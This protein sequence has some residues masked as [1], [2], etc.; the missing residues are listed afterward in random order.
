MAAFFKHCDEPS[1]SLKGT[2]F[3]KLRIYGRKIWVKYCYMHWIFT[4]SSSSGTLNFVPQ[5]FRDFMLH[6][7]ASVSNSHT[8]IPNFE[9][10]VIMSWCFYRRELFTLI[11]SVL[12]NLL[13]FVPLPPIPPAKKKLNGPT[14]MNIQDIFL[15][16]GKFFCQHILKC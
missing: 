14:Y 3:L 8:R 7:G 6:C 15:T 16:A 9:N 13:L 2:E 12:E 11:G 10:K 1:D 5:D 4:S